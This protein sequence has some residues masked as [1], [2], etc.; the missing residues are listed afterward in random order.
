ML[1]E[2]QNPNPQEQTTQTTD[3]EI[4]LTERTNEQVDL[5]LGTTSETNLTTNEVVLRQDNSS[6]LRN[7]RVT[8]DCYGACYGGSCVFLFLVS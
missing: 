7:C 2:T 5:E 4:E 6:H 3:T 1:N 8:E